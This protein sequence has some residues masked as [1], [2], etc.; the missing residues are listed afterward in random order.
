MKKLLASAAVIAAAVFGNACCVARGTRVRVPKGER[1]VEDLAVG[2]EVS[3]VDPV[4]GSI[5][6]GTIVAIRSAQRECVGLGVLTATSDHPLYCPDTAGYHPAGDWALGQRKHLLQVSDSGVKAVN[7]SNVERYA[8]IHEVFDLTVD[9]P[10]HNFVAN[11]I[12]VHNKTPARCNWSFPDGR[13]V[14]NE[15]EPCSCVG[16]GS[17]VLDCDTVT[18]CVRCSAT[19]GGGNP[20]AG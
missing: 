19:G 2:D 10:L 4:T 6:T 18:T 13:T 16:G 15:G 20:D 14:G 3:C 5:E 8:G 9:H 11:G 7:V 17:G 12:L 1:L